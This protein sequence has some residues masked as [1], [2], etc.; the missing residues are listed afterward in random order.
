MARRLT[1]NTAR[2]PSSSCSVMFSISGRTLPR[3]DHHRHAAPVGAAS[4][5]ADD[6]APDALA[7]QLSLAGDHEV[8][9]PEQ[10]VEVHQIQHGLDA[11]A[12]ACRPEE[13]QH[14]GTEAAGG[15][16]A[17][18]ICHSSGRSSRL[19]HGVQGSQLAVQKFHHGRRP[20]PS[21]GRRHRPRR[22]GR[23]RGL[24]MSHMAVI[25][26]SRRS[27][28]GLPQASMC[29]DAV[30][31]AAHRHEGLSRPRPGTR[32]PR[33]AAQPQPPSLVQLPPRPTR[34]WAVALPPPRGGSA[35]PRRRCWYGR[36]PSG[37]PPGEA[38]RR[39][40]SQ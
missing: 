16:G 9:A 6:L 14:P 11:G 36:G 30:Q 12:A 23:S 34:I 18:H 38:R 22:W 5:A 33:A 7:V 3:D 10:P 32:T 21:G 13:R 20:P 17:G 8:A 31:G 40:P 26:T 24:S 29:G 19:D 28:S 1:E 25:F 4:H 37:P 27:L 35:G 39:T 2:T 15:P